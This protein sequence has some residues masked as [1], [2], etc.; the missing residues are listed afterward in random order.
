MS[1]KSFINDVLSND[2]DNNENFLGVYHS[3]EQPGYN[4]LAYLIDK[5]DWSHV[6]YDLGNN[7]VYQVETANLNATYTGNT[8]RIIPKQLGDPE[9]T[10]EDMELVEYTQDNFSRNPASDKVLDN[11]ALAGLGIAAIGAGLYV[12]DIL[13]DK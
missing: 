2:K 11:I 4:D 8:A 6:S 5:N 7:T 13:E 9:L 1:A 3:L 12:K 10:A